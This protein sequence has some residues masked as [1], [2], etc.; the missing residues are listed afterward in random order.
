M[1]R[2]NA[3]IA[4]IEEFIL[5]YAVIIMAIILIGNVISRSV[6]NR[7]WTFAEETGSHLIIVTTFLGISYAARKGRHIRMSAFFDLLPYRLQ[8]IFILFISLFTALVLFYLAYLSL[9]YTITVYSMGRI[10]AA[11]RL[12]A[13]IIV[14]VVPLGFSLGGIQYLINFILN[15]K[16]KEVLIGSEKPHHSVQNDCS[17]LQMQGSSFGQ[18]APK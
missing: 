4:R 5:S 7:S 2:L 10:T 6:F 3:S 9:Q 1:K 8:K 14:A 12:P 11:L 13:Y 18:G 15:I 16:E 17:V